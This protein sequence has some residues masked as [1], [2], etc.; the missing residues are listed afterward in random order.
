MR[1]IDNAE[2][3]KVLDM[4]TAMAALRRAY[5]E[6]AVGESVYGPRIDY[7]APTGRPE[8]YHQWG[9]MVGVCRA[10]GVTAIRMKSDIVSWP[11]GT[12]Q[13]KYCLE[14]GRYCGLIM[15]FDHGNGVPL[16]LIQDGY[17]QHLRVGAAIG[18][19]VEA[20]ARPDAATLGLVGSGG[21][22]ATFLESIALVRRLEQVRVYS[23]TVGHR[24]RFAAEW[25]ARLGVE[26]SPVHDPHQAVRGADIVATATDS[27]RPTFEATWV[28]PGAH[29]VCVTRRELSAELLD[30]ADR[31]LQL[32]YHTISPG[33]A[34]PLMEWKAGG[35][36]SYV[37]GR[38]EE[39]SRIPPASSVQAAQFPTLADLQMGKAPGRQSPLERTLFIGTGTQGLQFAAVAG[40]LWRSVA[41][42][43]VGRE[44]PDEWL[45]ED[46]RD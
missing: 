37:A 18:L 33:A 12:T 2:V 20:L 7:Y 29:V 22:A 1:V 30:I 15:L 8:D 27:M 36:A 46:I 13:E 16:A 5:A 43:R 9:C 39:R 24:E 26:V 32:G 4:P 3:A 41:G 31:V 23:P 14:P 38:P 35:I 44:V 42:S 25:S 34:I 10:T 40:Q 6:L 19:G 45:L 17:L 28:E 21:M 11:Q